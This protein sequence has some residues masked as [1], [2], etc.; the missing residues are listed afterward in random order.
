MA[1]GGVAADGGTANDNLRLSTFPIGGTGQPGLVLHQNDFYYQ[2]NNGVQTVTFTF[3]RAVATV[4]FAV[5]DIDASQGDF[6]DAV[7]VPS[8]LTV[9]PNPGV[10]R[11]VSPTSGRVYYRPAVRKP[12]PNSSGNNNLNV[13]GE[14]LTSFQL[15][16]SN[17]DQN[18]NRGFDRDQR[19]F[20]TDFRVTI[21]PVGC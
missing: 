12:E 9:R 19:V 3:S 13:H 11:W 1:A 10:V 17:H 5:T 4:D 6:A 20:L 15:F 7:R 2:G 18:Y 21:P 8:N 16:Y 14:N